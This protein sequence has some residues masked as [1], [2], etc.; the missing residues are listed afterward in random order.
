MLYTEL[1]KIGFGYF[2]RSAKSESLDL[3]KIL[4][5]L[6]DIYFKE[7]S[8]DINVNDINKM[9]PFTENYKKQDILKDFTEIYNKNIHKI[10]QNTFDLKKL[11]EK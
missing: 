7:D 9:L 2:S 6:Q 11:N 1:K 8:E 3:D 4:K 10:N 5:I